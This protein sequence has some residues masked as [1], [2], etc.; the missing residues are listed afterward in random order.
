MADDV[1]S[2]IEE[3]MM[4]LEEGNFNGALRT[5]NKIIKEYP[6]NPEGYFGKAETSVGLPNMSIVDVAQLYRTA[7][8]LDPNNTYYY[9]C[10]AEF[11]LTNGIL[12]GE[13]YY[14][15]AA[16]L[17][18]DNASLYYNDL[19]ISYYTNGIL[20]FD[21]QVNMKKEDI[22][23]KAI[24]YFAKSFEIPAD[25]MIDYLQR[26]GKVPVDKSDID[27]AAIKKEMAEL[28]KLGDAKELLGLIKKEPDNPLI[29][30]N[31][32][33]LA[34]ESGLFNLGKKYFFEAIEIDPENSRYYYNDLAVTYYTNAKNI[35][36][37]KKGKGLDF[38]ED[39]IR[40][41][42]LR[43]SLE[44]L[45]FRPDRVIEILKAK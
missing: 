22:L 10:Y 29:I 36:K 31:L 2:L 42:S 44:A 35:M 38:D 13:Q 25:K 1:Q 15:K 12:Q 16:E 45:R 39:D 14:Q 17:D 30:I 20:F 5:F 41:R 24:S 6:D 27:T 8:K 37:E 18:P 33:Q 4:K 7:L 23:K 43:Y 32:G 11:C 28:E 19:A 26:S 40:V 34:F 3:G 21:R 9:T